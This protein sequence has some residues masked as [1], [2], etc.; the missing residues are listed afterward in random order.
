MG[1]KHE[2]CYQTNQKFVLLKS[3]RFGKHLVLA[4]ENTCVNFRKKQLIK[5]Q[6]SFQITKKRETAALGQCNLRN[7]SSQCRKFSSCLLHFH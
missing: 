1:C 6:L 2:H 3:Y 5:V 4:H 7:Y